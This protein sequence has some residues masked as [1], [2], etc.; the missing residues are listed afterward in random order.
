MDF[1]GGKL[2]QKRFFHSVALEDRGAFYALKPG[3]LTVQYFD[4]KL[5]TDVLKDI[6]YLSTKSLLKFKDVFC[7][8][9]FFLFAMHRFR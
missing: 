8:L 5:S 6:F 1:S 7:K 3:F 4:L 9:C 2:K